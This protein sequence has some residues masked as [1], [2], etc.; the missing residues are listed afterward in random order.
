VEYP[1]G[2]WGLAFFR[3]KNAQSISFQSFYFNN[4]P[5][6]SRN[7]HSASSELKQGNTFKEWREYQAGDRFYLSAAQ[8]REVNSL[9]EE[10][11]KRLPSDAWQIGYD[12]F[13][14]NEEMNDSY[15]LPE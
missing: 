15:F 8:C 10:A 1:S 13:H 5:I 7:P 2:N 9:N 4:L 3:P 11:V 6:K 12:N 14:A